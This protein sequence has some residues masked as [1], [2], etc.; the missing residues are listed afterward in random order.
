LSLLERHFRQLEKTAESVD[1]QRSE[2][3][4]HVTYP[5]FTA[6][7]ERITG[8]ERLSILETGSSSHGTDSSALFAKLVR[9]CGGH[10]T[11]VDIDA[12][13]T[14]NARR[15]FR[16]L[17]C[18]IECVARCTESVNF[19]R[20]SPDSYNVVYLDSYDLVPGLFAEAERHGYAELETLL[21]AQRLEHEALILIDDTPNSM[22][23]FARQAD[24]GYLRAVAAHRARHGR[25]PGK[26]ALILEWI[27][28]R[29]DFEILAHDYQLLLRY[30]ARN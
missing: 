11:T 2:R 20:S 7:F 21:A 4:G 19:I 1:V 30:A 27:T 22:E 16:A 25:L 12:L 18:G 13:A 10:F 14:A 15:I 28:G 24:A 5:T 29:R 9:S 6:L 23:A 8:F 3:I 26:G 17:G